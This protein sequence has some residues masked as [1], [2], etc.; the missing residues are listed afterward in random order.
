MIPRLQLAHSMRTLAAPLLFPV[1]LI[2]LTGCAEEAPQR[3]WGSGMLEAEVVTVASLTGGRILVRPVQEGDRVERGAL[4]AAIDSVGL[5]EA[6]DQARV[7]LAA[8]AVSR[9]QAATTLASAEER[10]LQA[11][12]TRDRLKALL[13]TEAVAR[14]QLDDAETVVTLATQQVSSARTAFETIQ[15][16]ERRLRL[17]LAS[18][19]RRI[20]ECRLT[21]PRSGTVLT[22]FSEPGEVAAP[23]MGI[24]RIA[25]L[26]ELYVRVY[27]PATLIG[28]VRLGGEAVVRV[29]SYPG[30]TFPGRVVH[31]AEEAEFTP[32]NVQTSEARADLV[33]AVKVAVPNPDGS[34]KIGLP[35]DVDLPEV[36]G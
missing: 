16:E 5:V 32:K 7:G 28:R 21:A 35:A 9:T 12:R 24:V 14:S 25:D 18:I 29:D 17:Q 1:L 26:S 36:G 34:L 10:L 19:G 31:I 2:A 33:Y 23:G 20:G 11:T 13:E 3:L 15:V 8:L 22:V 30:R 27:V 4:V 6:R